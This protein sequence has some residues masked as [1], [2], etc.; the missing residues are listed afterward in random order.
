ML[1][2]N[3]V[4]TL[5]KIYHKNWNFWEV[6]ADN[7]FSITETLLGMAPDLTAVVVVVVVGNGTRSDSSGCCC[8]WEWHQIW[9]QWLL[10]LGMAPDLKAVVLLRNVLAFC[11]SIM[12]NIRFCEELKVRFCMHVKIISNAKYGKI[13]PMSYLSDE[14]FNIWDSCCGDDTD[15]CLSYAALQM[16]ELGSSLEKEVKQYQTASHHIPDNS[17]IWGT[18]NMCSPHLAVL[19]CFN[20][21]KWQWP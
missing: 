13:N 10:L 1:F 3:P 9:Q 16:L 6:F 8:C 11:R 5:F 17:R 2:H 7:Y 20:T 12:C 14:I 21:G 19:F 18:G 15:S 4:C